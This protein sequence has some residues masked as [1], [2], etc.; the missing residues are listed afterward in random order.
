M[1]KESV[2]VVCAHS[3]D[4]I[5][6]VGGTLAKYAKQGK[7]INTVIFSYGAIT[8]P[9]VQEKINTGI[10]VKESQKADKIIGGS[11]VVFFGL[12]DG[13]F[14]I[15]AT[16]KD[17]INRLIEIIK[18][19]KPNKI[20][21]HNFDDPHPDHR[22]VRKILLDVLFEMDYKCDVYSF[23]IY[24]PFKLRR[25]NVPKLIVNISDTYKIKLRALNVFK[26]QVNLYA[27]INWIPLI[28]TFMRDLLNGINNNFRFAEVFYK[29][30]LK[31][32]GE[33]KS[34][35]SN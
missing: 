17:I 28:S 1:K 14:M 2:L 25:R 16:E 26:S 33:E 31:E 10:R 21:T 34:I 30:P 8:H 13:K 22:D 35:N 5:I 12:N 27:I 15:E 23:Q 6:G 20:F 4:Q 9:W 24:T 3:D 29:I 18:K 19:H 11:G 32:D 7:I